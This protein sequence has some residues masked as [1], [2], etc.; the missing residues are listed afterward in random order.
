M[1]WRFK[2]WRSSEDTMERG[3]S[4]N[5]PHY[6]FGRLQFYAQTCI[7]KISQTDDRFIDTFL[8]PDAD[9]N[10]SEDEIE[11]LIKKI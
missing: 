9:T 11:G 8:N 10:D 7:P 2:Q 1:R 4:K 3:K 6:D 5:I